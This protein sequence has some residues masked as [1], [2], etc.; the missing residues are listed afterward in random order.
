MSIETPVFK[1]ELFFRVIDWSDTSTLSTS[2]FS[3][4][5]FKANNL[6]VSL[7]FNVC[8]PCKLQS[9]PRPR[10]VITIVWAKSGL[11]SRLIEILSGRTI[12]F[13]FKYILLS[14]NFVSTPNCLYNS[15]ILESPWILFLKNDEIVISEKSESA[16]KL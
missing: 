2:N 5:F 16:T 8:R 12:L 4:S 6:S 9:T 15:T 14:L 1:S 7:I 3:I 11:F 10:Q 13:Y